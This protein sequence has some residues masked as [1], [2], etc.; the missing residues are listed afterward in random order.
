MSPHAITEIPLPEVQVEH[1]ITLPPRP[2]PA[3]S[4][5]GAEAS[6][7]CGGAF[8]K[9]ALLE[10][11]RV[12][13]SSKAVDVLIALTF[14]V[15][16]ISVPIFAG[17]YFTASLSPK[18]FASMLLVAPPPP[19]P[20]PPAAAAAIVQKQA[21]K[22]V[23]M[24]DGK[25]LA[26]TVVPK[27]IAMIK[28]APIEPDVLDGVAGCFPGGV[29][30]GQMGGVLGG[31][32]GGI[33]SAV[34][35]IVA[36][37]AP[38]S[39]APIRVGGRVRRPQAIRQVPPIYPILARDAHITGEV[40]IDAVLDE[41]GNVTDM[42]VLSGPVLLYPAALAALKEWKYEPTYL[43]DE[44]VSVQLIVTITFKLDSGR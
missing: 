18:E 5:P 6:P 41:H 31:V 28:E 22:H 32:L 15:L 38:H 42:K 30:G 19:P 26:P 36:P 2:A 11:H 7:A 12:K 20:P 24:N 13:G 16:V 35:P 44:P 37:A 4:R 27:D 23:F 14:H 21:P 40:V 8:L 3:Q 43:N 1:V 29:P 10:N 39:K 17:L 9:D 25:L 34:K 33:P